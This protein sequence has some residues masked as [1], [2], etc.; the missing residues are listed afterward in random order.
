MDRSPD[1]ALTLGQAHEQQHLQQQRNSSASEIEEDEKPKD[2]GEKGGEEGPP[3]P[4]GVWDKRMSKLRL[5]VFG[6]WA[7]T[8]ELAP[9]LYT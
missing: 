3:A 4:V 7:R 6:L 5:E 8:S 1:S 2:G 9:R